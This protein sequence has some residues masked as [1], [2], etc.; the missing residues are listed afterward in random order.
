LQYVVKKPNVLDGTDGSRKG[1]K[2]CKMAPEV[3]SQNTKGRCKCGYN[4][5][6]YMLRL[7]VRC[8]TEGIS[9]ENGNSFG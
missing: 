7:T 5:Y 9:I 8:E 6:L 2:M 1:E 4:T 3:G